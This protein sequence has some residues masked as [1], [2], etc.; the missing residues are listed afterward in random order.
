MKKTTGLFLAGAAVLLLGG[1]A[2]LRAEISQPDQTALHSEYA[3][4]VLI[5]RKSFRALDR[6]EV[7]RDG[8]VTGNP[9]PGFW[10]MD[11]AC[12]V[13]DLEFRKDSVTIKCTRLWANIKDDGKLHYFPASVLLKGKS[14]YPEKIDIVFRT[15]KT[16]VSAAEFKERLSQIFL[17]E[18]DS[19][20]AATP[21]PIAAYIQKL[22]I[23][24]D[25]DAAGT[26]PFEGTPPK[27]V[28]TP[29][30]DLSREARLVGQA[31]KEGFI[32][33]VDEEGKASVLGFTHLLQY[34]LEE[35][36]M[37][38]VKGW[39]F[40]PAMKDGKPVAVRMATEVEYKQPSANSP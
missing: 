14:D 25:I 27:P 26:K 13:K 28:A 36:T 2:A 38:A 3:N 12:Q 23:E 32:L 5:F 16:E 31:G 10:T 17:G 39:K 30:P 24:P 9:R 35:T 8:S 18:K 33:L 4:K 15:Q 19:V 1:A 20:L 29:V 11:G 7:N 34:G 21:T 6:L 37:E 22:T 40:Q